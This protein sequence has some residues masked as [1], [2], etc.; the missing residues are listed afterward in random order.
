[1]SRPEFETCI[2][3]KTVGIIL[4]LTR[5]LS[6]ISKAVIMDSG[7]CVLKGVFEMKTRGIYGSALIK[8]SLYWPRGVHG[9]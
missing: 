4:R 6:N 9:D 8:K 3:M 1:M 2:Q 5:S 7:F